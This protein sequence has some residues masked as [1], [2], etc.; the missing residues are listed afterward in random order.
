MPDASSSFIASCFPSRCA[1]CLASPLGSW[2]LSFKYISSSIELSNLNRCPFK[3]FLGNLHILSDSPI[4]QLLLST[5]PF[6]LPTS[7]TQ[8]TPSAYN[9]AWHTVKG[10]TNASITPFSPTLCLKHF[11]MGTRWDSHFWFLLSCSD[12]LPTLLGW[13]LTFSS[14][15]M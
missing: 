4:A 14:H 13:L 6:Q 7:R 8:A 5:P 2:Y 3:C 12:P 9:S 11:H 15:S 10:P 1:I